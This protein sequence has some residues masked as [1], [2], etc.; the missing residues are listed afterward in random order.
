MSQTKNFN[1]QV[2]SGTTG[3]LINVKGEVNCG[4]L[5]VQPS[6]TKT[7]PQG[8]NPTILLL[9]VYPASNDDKGA[10][11]EAEYNENIADSDTYQ[12]VQLL[13]SSGNIIETLSVTKA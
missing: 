6:L 12:S 5:E 10:F 2:F 1:A 8:V 13:D 7:N 3:L 4:M 11:R 9:D